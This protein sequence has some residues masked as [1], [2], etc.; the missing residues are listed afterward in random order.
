MTLWPG[1][2]YEKF[3]TPEDDLDQLQRALVNA[4]ELEMLA[5]DPNYLPR[6][7]VRD[8]KRMSRSLTLLMKKLLQRASTSPNPT[9]PA[10]KSIVEKLKIILCAESEGDSAEKQGN[11]RNV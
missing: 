2:D 8:C 10:E 3:W 5:E 11:E 1:S 6:D 9:L 7:R 4:Q